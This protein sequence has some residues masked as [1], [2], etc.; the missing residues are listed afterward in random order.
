[1]L[2]LYFWGQNCLPLTFYPYLSSET[3]PLK[4]EKLPN[5]VIY[6]CKNITEQMNLLKMD[7][8]I[9]WLPLYLGT[10]IMR[11]MVCT[12]WRV[13]WCERGGSGGRTHSGACTSSAFY[14]A[15]TPAVMLPNVPVYVNQSGCDT[16]KKKIFINMGLL[17]T[18]LFPVQQKY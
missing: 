14:T 18:N 16:H 9:A 2:C 1:M 17:L 12:R 4:Y 7:V 8:L 15:P 13:C 6:A 3:Y 5:I 11:N 10:Y